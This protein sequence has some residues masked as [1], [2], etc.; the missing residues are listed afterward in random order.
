MGCTFYLTTFLQLSVHIFDSV[1]VE[2]VQNKTSYF[3]S[4]CSQ[5]KLKKLV[6]GH[7][8]RGQDPAWFLDEVDVDI[9]V[10]DEQYKFRFGGWLGGTQP[11]QRKEVS[12]SP[13]E[14]QGCI[15]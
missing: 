15:I 7:D 10:R 6:I 13:G 14:T 11:G 9:P 5:T 1:F 8:D 4:L 12:L 3:T 2:G